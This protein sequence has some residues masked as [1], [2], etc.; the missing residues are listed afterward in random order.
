VGTE[1][2]ELST[3]LVL[4]NDGRLKGFEAFSK[5]FFIVQL[6]AGGGETTNAAI[7]VLRHP[8]SHCAHDLM[9]HFQ[10]LSDLHL[11]VE[12]GSTSPYAFDFPVTALNLALLGDIGWTRDERLFEW[13]ELQ[14]SRF[15][16]V[17]FVIGNHEPRLLTLVSDFSHTFSL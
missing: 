14:L 1:A 13:L 10:L 2:D 9:Q 17:F 11:E 16:R 12:R 4:D 7:S 5:N 15:E 3:V 6:V 8:S